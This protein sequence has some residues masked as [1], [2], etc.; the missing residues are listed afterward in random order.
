[1]RG[2]RRPRSS[3]T[4][5]RSALHLESGRRT[6]RLLREQQHDIAR[7]MGFQDE[8]RLI[9]EDGL[10]RTVFEHARGRGCAHRGRDRP[11]ADLRAGPPI[12]V[13]VLHD[14]DALALVA[15]AAEEGRSLSAAELDAVEVIASPDELDVERRGPRGVPAHPPRGTGG[16]GRPAGARSN[17][18]A[19]ALIPEWADVRCRPQRDPYHR[20]TVDVHLLR[21]FERMSRALAEPDADD[22]RRGRGGRS[23]PGTGR[24][25]C[26]GALLH[27]IGK[28][29][30]GGHVLVGDRVARRR[31]S[32]AWVSRRRRA[33]SLGSWSAEHLLLPDTATQTRPRRRR[34]DPG[35]RRAGRDAGTARRRCT[36]SRR[37]TRSPPARR[38]GRRG[39]RR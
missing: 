12:T 5:V 38:R 39:A 30:E 35:R 3:Y 10:M 16:D 37:P 1:M 36:C 28:N 33:S 6:D 25:R 27:D 20:Y 22:P 15:R 18:S 9:A 31:S 11:T 32:T 24:R 8:P 13:E 7:V 26:S 23:H 17:R 14:A 19:R 4:R 2:W 34:P 21:A 29:G